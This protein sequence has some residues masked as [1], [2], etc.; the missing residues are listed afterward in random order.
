VDEDFIRSFGIVRRRWSGG[1]G[2]WIGEADVCDARRALRFEPS[3]PM[4]WPGAPNTVPVR[5]VFRRFYADGLALAKLEVGFAFAPPGGEAAL[6]ALP[7]QVMHHLLEL[8]VRIPIPGGGEKACRLWE[9]GNPLAQLYRAS[10][11]RSGTQPARSTNWQV[12][13]GSPSSWSST[14]V[15]SGPLC[16]S[17]AVR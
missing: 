12:Q 7:E 2:G 1:L 3:A 15:L 5:I 9:T 4:P 16:P 10:S 8:R 11:S 17:P 13:S 6:Q 14:G